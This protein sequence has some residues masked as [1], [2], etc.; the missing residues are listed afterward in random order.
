ML[1]TAKLLRTGS[2]VNA[3]LVRAKRAKGTFKKKGAKS[4]RGKSSSTRPSKAVLEGMG[5]LGRMTNPDFSLSERDKQYVYRRILQTITSF[6]IRGH[7]AA[8]LDPLREHKHDDKRKKFGVGRAEFGLSRSG[9]STYT[10]DFLPDVVRFL[11]DFKIDED[12]GEMN[13]LDLS[14][15]PDLHK[16]EHIDMVLDKEIFDMYGDLRI[17]ADPHDPDDTVNR[18]KMW[19]FNQVIAALA[20]TYAGNVGLETFHIENEVMRKWLDS[21]IEGKLSPTTSRWEQHDP[22]D[23]IRNL[24]YLMR[25][26]HT[27]K[28]LNKKYPSS[29]VFGIEGCE[30]LLPGLWS[31][32]ARASHKHGVEAVEMG[33]AHRGRMNILHNLLQ[34]P[35]QALCKDFSEAEQHYGDVKY[36]LGTRSVIDVPDRNGKI[37]QLYVS[38]AA[39]PS[40]L[41]AVNTVVLG[42][43][44]AKQQFIGDKHGDKVVPILLHGDASF[45]G[46]GIVP[47]SLELSQCKGYN[48][49]GTVHIIL[50][51]QIGFTTDPQDG[52]AS[53]HCTD[54]AKGIG[55]PIF[56][57]NGDDVDAVVEVC[58]M[59]IDFRMRFKKDVVVD[60]VCYRRHGHNELDDPMIT[61]PNMYVPPLFNPL[62]GLI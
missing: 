60:I 25:A 57:V 19:S 6:R 56:H 4:W 48:V 8:T 29:K 1:R 17:A 27:A 21:E 44:K 53:Y 2:R 49:G 16:I 11:R 24:E 32:V 45:S 62:P 13:G 46:Q 41:E 5:E 3:S 26:D 34:K 7:F 22:S 9:A 15:F 47:E 50:N 12:T 30:S 23:Q 61:H 36:H 14:T 39:N 58:Q 35:L 33:M 18:Y 59:A 52:R 43:T 51:N 37:N 10:N 55:S 42:K 28:F 40:H 20:R 54:N 38:L 31:I